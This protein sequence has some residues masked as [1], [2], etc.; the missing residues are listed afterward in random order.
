MLKH[1]DFTATGIG[2][3]KYRLYVF[4]VYVRITNELHTFFSLINSN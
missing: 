3:L 1:L 2:D 4:L